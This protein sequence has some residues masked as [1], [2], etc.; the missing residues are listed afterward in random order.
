[1]CVCVCVCVCVC[2]HTCMLW[3]V[4]AVLKLLNIVN[5][6][7]PT[8][9]NPSYVPN[10]YA[11]LYFLVQIFRTI[12]FYTFVCLTLNANCFSTDFNFCLSF[13]RRWF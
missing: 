2:I 1:M 6:E 11:F 12:F 7:A 9:S 3:Y 10:D 8:F 4:H 13:T 5:T